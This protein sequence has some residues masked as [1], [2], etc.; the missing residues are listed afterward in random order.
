MRTGGLNAA[1]L[2]VATGAKM[3]AS[4]AEDDDSDAAFS[5]QPR[6]Q[7]IQRQQHRVV[8]CIATFW[9]IEGDMKPPSFLTEQQRLAFWLDG[10][11]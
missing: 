9:T 6:D 11:A 5:L 1:F 10:L 7:A 2:D 3:T 4:A 8:K